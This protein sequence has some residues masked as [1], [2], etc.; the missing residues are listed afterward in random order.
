[1]V[2]SDAEHIGLRVVTKRSMGAVRSYLPM[3]KINSIVPQNDDM[4]HL[5]GRVSLLPLRK[6]M[7]MTYL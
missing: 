2:S 6:T 3:L 4:I 7:M 5:D 1:M